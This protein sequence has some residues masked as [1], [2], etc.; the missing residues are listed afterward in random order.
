[1]K[2][3]KA[4]APGRAAPAADVRQLRLRALEPGDLAHT[5]VW[6]NDP[7]ITRFT[8]TLFPIGSQ[9][10]EEW[11]RQLVHDPTRRAFALEA[12]DGR[13]VGNGGFRDIQAI[14]RK[15]EIWLYIGDRVR[16]NAGLGR[17]AITELVRFGFD[18]MN[19]HRIWARVFCYNE[20]ALRAFKACGFV[21]E[22][23][24]RDDS[25][26][27]GRYHDSHILAILNPGRGGSPGR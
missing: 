8:G 5:L 18:R 2:P 6:V 1:L 22:G 19:L 24:L 7:E 13:Y 15:A 17:A 10:H 12:P 9:E 14:P 16:Q 21:P 25:F 20:P 26:R 23:V 27:D 3:K 4:G 11:Y